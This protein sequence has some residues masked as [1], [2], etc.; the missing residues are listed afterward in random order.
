MK[1]IVGLFRRWQ[2][3]ARILA[4]LRELPEGTCPVNKVN[5]IGSG[6]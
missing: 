4:H 6:K 1:K 3:L 2:M 5:G